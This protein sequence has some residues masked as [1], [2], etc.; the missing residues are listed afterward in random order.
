MHNIVWTWSQSYFL[1]KIFVILIVN[2]TTCILGM[3]IDVVSAILIQ[4]RRCIDDF[5]RGSEL[6]KPID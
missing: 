5:W 4:N 1:I 3:K 6:T 2:T